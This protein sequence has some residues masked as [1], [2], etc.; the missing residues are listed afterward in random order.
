MNQS[1]PEC[2]APWR[3]NQTCQDAFHQMLFW[4]NENPAYGEVHHLLVLCYHLQHPS[5][6]SPDG[7]A[8]ARRL[9]AD[10]L[11]QNL[12]PAET[13]RR[14]RQQVSSSQRQWKITARPGLHGAYTR[15]PQWRLTAAAVVAGGAENYCDNVRQWAASILAALKQS[16]NFPETNP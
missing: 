9:L 14:N 6:Y 3:D 13:R 11:E 16:G 10:F 7:L 1:C 5:L 8:G 2:G 15:P 12:P 4:E